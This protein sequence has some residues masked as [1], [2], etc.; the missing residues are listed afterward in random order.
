M[1]A[2]SMVMLS[3]IA[4][5]GADP[6]GGASAPVDVCIGLCFLGTFCRLSELGQPISWRVETSSSRAMVDGL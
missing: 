5:A 2:F 6:L 4:G 3:G 1:G